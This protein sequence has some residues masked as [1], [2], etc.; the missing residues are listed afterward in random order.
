MAT[1]VQACWQSLSHD[2]VKWANP[3]RD[4]S[5]VITH[6][7]EVMP[8]SLR[9]LLDFMLELPADD[10]ARKARLDYIEYWNTDPTKTYRQGGA[11]FSMW[12]H[13]SDP[14]EMA[15]IHAGVLV[16]I[17]LFTVGLFTSSYVRPRMARHCELYPPHSASAVRWTP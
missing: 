14:T 11:I 16:L 6:L 7:Y 15:L 10:A 1:E 13:V 3:D 17:L 9:A 5:Y 8:E 4:R 2:R 12:F